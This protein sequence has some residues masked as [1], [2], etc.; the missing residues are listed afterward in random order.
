MCIRDS[1][2][3]EYHF[4]GR[5]ALTHLTK[6][7]IAAT[8]AEPDD[9]EGVTGIPRAIEGVE[10]GVTLRQQ[11]TGSYKISVRTVLGKDAS[12][13]AAH[14]GGG[15]HKQAAGCELLGSL[16]NAKSA[17]LAEVERELCRES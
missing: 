11:P 5:C 13:I 10:V 6:E 1:E 15:G 12:A 16:E 9:L 7:E 3:L 17:V 14:L 4:D 2:N 8:G